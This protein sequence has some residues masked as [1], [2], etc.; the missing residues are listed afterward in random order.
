VVNEAEGETPLTAA[1][2]WCSPSHISVPSAAKQMIAPGQNRR[3]ETFRQSVIY[4]PCGATLVMSIAGGGLPRRSRFWA[5]PKA[6]TKRSTPTAVPT[7]A[8]L[9]PLAD[10]VVHLAAEAED[11]GPGCV[12]P[13]AGGAGCGR[14]G[15]VTIRVTTYAARQPLWVETSGTKP[16]VTV[17]L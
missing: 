5:S 2:Y 12:L 4:S 3:S 9:S 1:G 10:A 16:Q 17:R 15:R 11:H 7:C 8:G 13:E 6:S 14:R